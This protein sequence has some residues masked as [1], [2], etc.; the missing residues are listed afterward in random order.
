[1]RTTPPEQGAELSSTPRARSPSPRVLAGAWS[2]FSEAKLI[3]VLHASAVANRGTS[4]MHTAD[5]RSC[6]FSIVFVYL[7]F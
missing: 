2:T 6:L 3:F 7:S 1:M 5:K 4:E